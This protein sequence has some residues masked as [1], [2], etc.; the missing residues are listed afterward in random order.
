[1]SGA[2]GSPSYSVL[3]LFAGRW[4]NT[5]AITSLGFYGGGTN[6]KTN[7]MLSTYV[8]PKNLIERQELGSAAGS[9]TF[10]SIPQTYDHLE[11]SWYSNSDEDVTSIRGVSTTFNGDTGTNYAAQLLEGQS[12]IYAGSVTGQT[13]MP[14]VATTEGA[15]G[16]ANEMSG[17][18]FTVQNYTKT[19]RHKHLLAMSGI[20]GRRIW[21]GSNRWASTAAVTS[22]TLTQD[23]S[24]DFI[25]G[26]VFTLRGIHSTAPATASDVA[27]LNGIAPADIT[28]VN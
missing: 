16:A 4:N 24:G 11:V 23:G 10:S 21:F 25:A 2:Q 27:A 28:A 8:V 7:S 18:T 15:S 3:R 22:I 9:V 20:S 14:Y 12:S 1:M 26:S 5:A 19:D 13:N 6:L 17:G